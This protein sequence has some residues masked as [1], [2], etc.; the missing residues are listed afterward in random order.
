MK[1]GLTEKG[2]DTDEVGSSLQNPRDSYID[3]SG[4]I[5]MTAEEPDALCDWG[6]S[7]NAMACRI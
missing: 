4:G 6:V 2:L 1:P 3:V 5:S 7:E